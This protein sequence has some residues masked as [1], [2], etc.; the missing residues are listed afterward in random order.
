MLKRPEL[1]RYHSTAAERI[2]SNKHLFTT[3]FLFVGGFSKYV[4]LAVLKVTWFLKERIF[5]SA[6]HSGWD[7]EIRVQEMYS[8]F[9]MLPHNSK[10]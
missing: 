4:Q 2:L 9:E 7:L 6:Q 8:G 1:Q 5:T 10:P 3:P